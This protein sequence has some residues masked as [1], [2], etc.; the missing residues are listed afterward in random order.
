MSE[1]LKRKVGT[2]PEGYLAYWS[3]KFPNLLITCW[4]I[5]YSLGWEKEDRF[6]DY[7]LPA[8]L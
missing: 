7:Y 1:E 6:K 2:L 4:G 5:V 8:G 3:T